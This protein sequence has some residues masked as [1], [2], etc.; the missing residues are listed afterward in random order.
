MQNLTFTED[1]RAF[2]NPERGFYK[3]F[4]PEY[5]A[6]EMSA[7]LQAAQLRSLR[8]RPEAL[9]LARRLFHLRAFKTSEISPEGLARIEHDFNEARRAGVKLIIR[10]LYDYSMGNDDAEEH[11][12][13]RHIEQLKPIMDKHKDVIAWVHAGLYGG[14]GEANSSDRGYVE[15]KNNGWHSLSPAGIRL[16]KQLLAAIPKDRM[17]LVRYP[18]FKWDLLNW[19]PDLAA[20]RFLTLSTAFSASEAARIG[21]YSDGFMGD[22][23]HFAFFAGFP[24][25]KPFVEKDAAFV[26][27]DGELSW[28]TD[29]QLAPGQVI[30]DMTRYHWTSLNIEGD[31]F[32]AKDRFEPPGH[33]DEITMRMGYRFRLLGGELPVAVPAGSA[34]NVRLVMRNDGFQG[35]VNPRGIRI[36]LR[37]TKS[38]RVFAARFDD[39]FGNRKTLPL[40]GE[41]KTLQFAASVPRTAPAGRY[42]VSLH[43]NDPAPSL[44]SRPEYSIRLANQGIW[45]ARTGHNTLGFIQIAPRGASSS[46][47]EGIARFEAVR[48]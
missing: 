43:L 34:L 40:A 35:I 29:Y 24:Q 14:S 32:T 39:G 15:M 20:T 1:R 21:Y 11:I 7:P 42:Q 27:I 37:E 5:E 36:V 23:N 41:T 30:D 33:Y 18:R 12:I 46:S 38:G 25:E 13:R 45:D 47:R 4:D 19:S 26:A 9:S 22:A 10:F 31:Q 2:P 44:A 16:Y 17:M 6:V 28:P 48:E 3:K 8:N